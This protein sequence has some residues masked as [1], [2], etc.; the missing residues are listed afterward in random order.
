M[1]NLYKRRFPKRSKHESVVDILRMND[2]Q[3]HQFKDVAGKYLGGSL[4][5]KKK[6]LPSALKKI[7]NLDS[8]ATLAAMIHME[9]AAHDDPSKEYHMGGGLMESSTSIFNS[10]WN[11]IGLGPEFESWFGH[12]DY[13]SPEN[14]P[15]QED[16]DYARILQQSYLAVDDRDDTV[17]DWVR[18]SDLDTDRFSVWVDEDDREVHVALRGTKAEMGDILADAHIIWD[19]T[20]GN[21]DDVADFLE[22]VQDKYE[23]YTL[24]A[25]GHSL[26]GNELIEVVSDRQL[27]QYERFNLFNPGMNPMWG[28]DNAKDIVQDERMTFYLNTGDILSNTF[29]SLID[30]ATNVVWSKPTHSPLTNHSLT[31][32]VDEI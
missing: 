5:S 14:R 28:L 4:K 10:L 20:S 15:S 31:Q 19:N 11:T 29:I 27:D 17:D 32:W 16:Q 25:S 3:F 8:P 24:D 26:G 23:G 12:Y 7:K 21:V 9:E 2:T 30:D 1:K 13:D 6:L 22:K 18:D